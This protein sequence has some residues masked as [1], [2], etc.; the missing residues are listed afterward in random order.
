MGGVG[1]IVFSGQLLLALPVALLAGL[2]S[3]ASPCVLPL[4]PGYLAYVGGISDPG[5]KRDRSRVLTGVALF[6][7]GFAVVFI[8][9][10]AAFGA[11][12]FWLVRWQEVVIRVLGA[13]VIVMGL[14]FI[15]QFS[16]LQRTIKP[17]WRPATGLIGAPLLGIVFGLGWTPCIGPTLAAIS[18]LS[19]G[20]GSPWRGALLG[21]F[22]CIGLGIPFLLVALGF[23]WVA[24]SVAFL[25]RHIRAINII[26]GVLLVVIGVLMVTGL[27]SELMSQFLAVIQGFEPAL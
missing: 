5:A 26:G 21:L 3:F 19:V 9:Y 13:L 12:G 17:S 22:Y 10:G 15:G 7:L 27:W 11:L 2:V 6:I 24:G 18:A 16:F 1:Q 25:K 20:S 4:V 23:D 8:A 14:V